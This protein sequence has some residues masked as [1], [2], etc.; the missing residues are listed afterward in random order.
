MAKQKRPVRKQPETFRARDLTP[1]LTVTD[2][3][4]SLAWYETVL[5]FTV[6]RQ[7]EE[8]GALRGAVLKAGTTRLMLSQ[9]DWARGRERHKGDGVRF[10]FATAQRLESL[11]AEIVARGGRLDHEPRMMPWGERTFALT[12]PDGYH[13]MIA[14]HT[15][16]SPTT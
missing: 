5:G 15:P 3:R 2:L 11:A 14:E 8:D 7:W 10:R 9:D 1:S 16:S 4:Q 6:D 12:D 13:L